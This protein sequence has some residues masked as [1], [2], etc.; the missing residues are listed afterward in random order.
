MMKKIDTNQNTAKVSLK[1][2]DTIMKIK[3]IE[4]EIQADDDLV[5]KL[6]TAQAGPR[7][8]LDEIKSWLSNLKA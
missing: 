7:Q 2:E 8:T 5:E 1:E 4:S 6:R 3:L